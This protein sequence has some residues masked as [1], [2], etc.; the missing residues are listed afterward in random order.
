MSVRTIKLSEIIAKP[1]HK[2]FLSKVDHQIDQGGRGSTKTSKNALKV[3]YH[4]IKEKDCNAV[5]FRRYQNTLRNSV[6]K[7]IKRACTRLGLIE[8]VDYTS[9]F[10]P[11]E[12]KFNNK[13]KI[14]FAGGDDYEKTKGMIDE[15]APIKIVWYEEL[16]EFDSEDDIDQITATFSRG[17]D[18]WFINLYSYNPPKNKYHWV[19]QWYK[20]M[21][22][23]D[24]VIYTHT[25]YTEIPQEWLG[26]K[27]ISRAEELKATDIDRYRW[28]YLGEV[29]GVEGLI[30][31]PDLM[32]I[33]EEKVL[34]TNFNIRDESI[35]IIN[36]DFVI[37]SGHQTSATTCLAIGRGINGDFYLLDTY[38]YSPN[39]KVNKKAP[40]DLSLDIF[41]FKLR[42]IQKYKANIDAQV[43]DSAE[44]ALRNQHFR[45]YGIRLKPVAKMEKEKMIDYVQ[46]FLSFKNFKVINNNNNKI[47]I[48]EI[49]NYSWKEGSVEK[50]KPVPDKEEKRFIGERYF[51]SY[52]QDYAGTYADHT[53]DAFQYWVIENRQKL[54][55]RW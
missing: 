40:S 54:G 5:V 55:L 30:Y 52:T 41:Q 37:D 14:Y 38:Y 36:I 42:V 3:V 26:K 46:N 4:L 49:Q 16:T 27:F 50:G 29:I 28:I 10:A 48:K 32:E 11:M 1:F 8:D 24:N 6:Y 35:R 53:Q 22:E 18:D 20:R 25:N 51:N 47:F 2:T 34:K 17:N 31:N 43:I 44:G 7:E 23:K 33:V 21:I 12:I 19:N 45:D 9:S 15:H 13:N 39:E